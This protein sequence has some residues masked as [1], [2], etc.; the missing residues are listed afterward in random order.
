[1]PRV[2]LWLRAALADN[3]KLGAETEEK[4]WKLLKQYAVITVT[5]PDNET[6]YSGPVWG[7]LDTDTN[8]MRNDLPLGRYSGTGTAHLNL[9]LTLDQNMPE[10]LQGLLGYV[11]WTL[12]AAQESAPHGAGQ[13]LPADGHPGK[14]IGKVSRCKAKGRT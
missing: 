11:D 5:G 3:N 14:V 10:E 7:N 4:I 2:L 1:M 9:T 12:T 8:T 13:I 6:L